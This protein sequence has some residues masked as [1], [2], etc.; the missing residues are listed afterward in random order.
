MAI[1]SK[2]SLD[3]KEINVK[4]KNVVFYPLKLLRIMNNSHVIHTGNY[5]SKKHI[6]F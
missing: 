5:F 2:L 3:V 6:I 4:Y 1:K